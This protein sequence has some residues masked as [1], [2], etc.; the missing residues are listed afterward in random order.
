LAG[1]CHN[2]ERS[3]PVYNG[4]YTTSYN[5]PTAPV[6]VVNG[7]GGNREGVSG[8]AEVQPA[9]SAK[10]IGQWGYGRLAAVDAHHLSWEWYT[11]ADNQLQDSFTISK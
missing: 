5:T 8:F 9:W 7:A 3:Y 10:R 1:H 6:Y 11:S 2:Y 4:Q